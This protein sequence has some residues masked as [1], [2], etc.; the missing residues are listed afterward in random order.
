MTGRLQMDH[1]M[2]RAALAL[3]AAAGLT[4][5]ATSV[6]MGLKGNSGP[7]AASDHTCAI[8]VGGGVKCWGDNSAGG[9][10]DG[11]MTASTTPVGVTGLASGVDAIAAGDRFSCALLTG[12]G[13]KCWGYNEYGQL[14]DGTTTNSA[15]P[16]DVVGLASGVDGIAARGEHTCALISGSVKCWGAN[17]NGQLGDGT[18]TSS[19]LPVDVTGLSSGVIAIA[20]GGEHTCAITTGGNVKCWGWNKTGQLGIGTTSDSS[21]PV[22]V[23]GLARDVKAVAT[24][25][26][27]T[28]A[29]VTAGAVKCWG[30]DEF[31]QLGNGS[32]A[33]SAIPVDVAGLTGSVG[34]ITTGGNLTC[35]L[36]T[37][38][39]V[40]CWGID[41]TG[42]LAGGATFDRAAPVDVAGL[43]G[44]V[45]T[46]V[47]GY[48]HLCATTR[49]GGVMCWGGNDTGQLGNGTTTDS[50]T[51]IAVRN[52]DGTALVVART[53]AVPT[54]TLLPIAIAAAIGIVL[55]LAV[56]W[57]AVTRRRRQ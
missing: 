53:D 4:F 54:S 30:Y 17:L 8:T 42:Q 25:G 43:T 22:D 24:G 16:V 51:P 46:I 12:G 35:A 1:R 50:S 49:D 15:F 39:G 31:G 5:P 47:A 57:Y 20:T 7:I 33:N 29:L 44:G 13:V 23:V 38:S 10:G 48:Y 37:E 41:L 56:G 18:T 45:A 52:A 26:R 9:L 40:S 36:R 55:M 3:V 28:C 14:G 21:I 2:P 34:A 27:H 6:A 32:T 11:T 19:S